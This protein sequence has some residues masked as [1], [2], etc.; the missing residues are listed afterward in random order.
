MPILFA[1]LGQRMGLDVTL[2]TAPLHLQMIY[3]DRA[4]KTSIYVEATSGGHPQREV[5]IRHVNPSMTDASI[6]NGMY[7]KKLDKPQAISVMAGTVAQHLSEKHFYKKT[8]IFSEILLKAYPQ[9]PES[10]LR[11]GTSM[12]RLSEVEF[13][14]VYVDH[15]HINLT[16]LNHEQKRYYHY[17]YRENQRYFAKAESLRWREET[18]EEKQ[19]Y[20]NSIEKTK[21]QT[22]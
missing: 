5:W 17:L 21:A 2:T 4:S 1:I 13:P 16:G 7:L 10:L 22:N 20:L 19:N 18:E 8:I 9:N 15:K 6:K 11:I 12:G 3:T 14:V